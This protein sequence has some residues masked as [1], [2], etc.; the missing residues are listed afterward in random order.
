MSHDT[1]NADLQKVRSKLV[2]REV[3]YCV[4]GLVDRIR[5]C[6]EILAIDGYSEED[7]LLPL[8]QKD[9]LTH[10]YEYECGCGQAQLH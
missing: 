5:K 8:L 10:E 2:E 3:I 6:S 9:R 7:D 1:T 4:S